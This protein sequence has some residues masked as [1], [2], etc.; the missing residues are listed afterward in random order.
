[1]KVHRDPCVAAGAAGK[2]SWRVRGCVVYNL[3]LLL[4]NMPYTCPVLK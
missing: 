2:N 3:K 1:M 4:V